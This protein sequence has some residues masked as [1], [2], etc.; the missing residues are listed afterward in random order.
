MSRGDGRAPAR[1]EVRPHLA[2]DGIRGLEG[3]EHQPPLAA[4]SSFT[5]APSPM[6]AVSGMP[7]R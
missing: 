5:R 7:L 1:P 2:V 6:A 3:A 4:V